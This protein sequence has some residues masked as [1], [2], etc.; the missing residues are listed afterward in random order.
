MTSSA[1]G[2]RW[3]LRRLFVLAGVGLVALGFANVVIKGWDSATTHQA[4][5]FEINWVAAHRLLDGEPLYDRDATREDAVELVGESHADLYETTFGSYIG[6]PSTALL[7]VPFTAFG[8]SA[9]VDTFRV[10]AV[11]AVAAAIFVMVSLL[12]RRSRAPAALVS[13]GVML[14]AGPFN[15]S[16]ELGQVDAWIILGLAVGIWGLFRDHDAVAGVGF[17]VAT[18]LKLSPVLVLVY[19]L[20]RGRWRPVAVA[21][22]T[23]IG[24][25]GVA[26]AIG[27]PD[28]VW[29]WLRDVTGDV[30]QGSIQ[31]D[32]QSLP[33]WIAR[34]LTDRVDLVSEFPLGSWRLTGWV[35]VAVAVPLLW[36]FCRGRPLDVLEIGI[37]VAIAVLAAPLSWDFYAMWVLVLL[38]PMVDVERWEGR[39]AR[40]V[41]ALAGTLGLGLVLMVPRLLSPTAKEVADEPLQRF[42]SGPRTGA[43]VLWT[44]VACWLL[45]RAR[46]ARDQESI[47]PMVLSEVSRG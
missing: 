22:A 8:V 33:A 4:Y 30:A 29:V 32:N 23:G 19:L 43:L 16:I 9:A 20:L 17:G 28:D 6:P 14:L 12:P 40:E 42:L 34:L 3:T 15:W 26:A 21:A 41:V 39:S 13:I 35:I 25:L 18:A 5:D 24:L 27:R 37:V 11:L 1:T 45:F 10:L 31:V 36:W 44:G 47:D 46:P 2:S 7:Y 38:V